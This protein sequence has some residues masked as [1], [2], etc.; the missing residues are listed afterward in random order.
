MT[1]SLSGKVRPATIESEADIRDGI[2]VLRRRCKFIRLMHDAAG[3]PPLRRRP[4]GFEGLARIIVG[5]QVSVASAEAIWGRVAAL[6]TPFDAPRLLELEDV[7]LRTAGLSRGKVRTLQALA[8]A[9]ASGLDLSALDGLDD[10]A[11]REVLTAVPGIGPWTADVYVMFCLGRCDGFCPGDLAL[12]VAAQKAL[13]LDARPS[14]Q[15]LMEI[16]ERWRPWRGVAA[17]MLWAYYRV[18]KAPNSGVPV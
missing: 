14:P 7:A 13:Q 9:M 12:Q 17:R 1:A 11:V 8:T 6:A 3:D 18:A 5:Q 16:A 2:R 15:E 10:I 4:G